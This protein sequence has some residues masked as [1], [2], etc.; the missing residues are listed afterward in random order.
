MLFTL[1]RCQTEAPSLGL[2]HESR[3]ADWNQRS[4]HVLTPGEITIY[5]CARKV[6]NLIPRVY[7]NSMTSILIIKREKRRF[8]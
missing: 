3:G 7:T 5:P 6:D 8:L 1:N 4:E 2:S